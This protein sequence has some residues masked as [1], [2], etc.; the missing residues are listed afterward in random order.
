MTGSLIID[1]FPKTVVST[2]QHD[3]VHADRR[4]LG[5]HSERSRSADPIPREL[6]TWRLTFAFVALEEA[7]HEEFFGERG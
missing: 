5:Q 6:F 1:S 2:Y 7:G 4:G 3:L